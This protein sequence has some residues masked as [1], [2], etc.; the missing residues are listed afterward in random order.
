MSRETMKLY[1]DN[2]VNPAGSCLPM[3][4]RGPGVHV[5]VLYAV[6]HSIHSTNGNAMRWARST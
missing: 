5:H 3:L 4:I 1:Q 6:G 2:D